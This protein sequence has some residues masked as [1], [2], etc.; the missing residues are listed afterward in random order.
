MEEQTRIMSWPEGNDKTH[1]T[2]EQRMFLRRKFKRILEGVHEARITVDYLR[3]K[4]R[5]TFVLT[6]NPGIGWR[7]M[8]NGDVSSLNLQ[9]DALS[10]LI[11]RLYKEIATQLKS[12]S[13]VKIET[14]GQAHH[15]LVC[16]TGNTRTITADRY[17]KDLAH[18]DKQ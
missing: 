13:V 5:A 12:K 7:L 1:T 6:C 10:Y 17:E 3:G 15:T 18:M 16:K 11:N 4:R 8:E 9:R 14:F 2:V